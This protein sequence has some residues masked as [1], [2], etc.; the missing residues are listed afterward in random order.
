MLRRSLFISIIVCV[1]AAGVADADL[2]VPEVFKYSS[3]GESLPA[4]FAL[5]TFSNRG[6]E[7]VVE[8]R[9]RYKTSGRFSYALIDTRDDDIVRAGEDTFEFE[10]TEGS[11]WGDGLYPSN[12][13]NLSVDL[14][15]RG[16]SIRYK[17]SARYVPY[18][19][20]EWQ[21][22]TYTEYFTVRNINGRIVI[23]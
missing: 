15:A 17:V 10:V 6:Y 1:V 16:R 20:Y 14:P 7:R 13:V 11:I 12:E 23:E 2:L 8:L 19:T 4:D 21:T 18:N 22:V 5:S 9:I 3:S